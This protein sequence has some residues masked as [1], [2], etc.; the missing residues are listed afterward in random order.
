MQKIVIFGGTGFLGQYIVRRLAKTD[1]ALV[2]PTRHS[3]RVMRLKPLG[4]VGQISSVPFGTTLADTVRDADVVIN[5]VGI[6]YESGKSTFDRVHHLFAKDLAEA[7]T[8]VDVKKLIHLSAIGASDKS[9]ARYARSKAAGEAAVLKAFPTATILRPSLLF[10]PE[11]NFFNLFARMARWSPVLPLP[12]GGETR[13]QPAYVD[14]IANAVVNCLD[15]PDAMGK[16]YELGGEDIYSFKEMLQLICKTL[17]VERYLLPLPGIM[18]YPQ[19]LLLQQLPKP[20]MT[21]DQLR[22]LRYDNVVSGSLPGFK[23]I[24]ITPARLSVVLPTYV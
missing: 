3:E 2:I 10:G 19:A 12:L 13:F 24:G 1:A 21:L 9:D 7:C 23:D 8:S 11:D 18:A 14:D 6:L 17:K 20:L 5:L 15:N 4:S 16:T 22:L